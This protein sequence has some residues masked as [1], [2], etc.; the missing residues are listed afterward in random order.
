MKLHAMADTPI[1]A[2]LSGGVD[3]TG[4]V[5]L[6][7][8]HVSDLRTYTVKFPDCQARMKSKRQSRPRTFRLPPHRGRSHV[9]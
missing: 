1:G 3:S 9:A 4:I 5:G 2:F 7:R 6:M 8:E